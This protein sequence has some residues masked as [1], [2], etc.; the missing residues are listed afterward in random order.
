M[1][2]LPQ[3]FTLD[4]PYPSQT[5][6]SAAPRKLT[7]P[8]AAPPE[9]FT[10]DTPATSTA[11]A[12]APAAGARL[13]DL[14]K[15][16]AG[17][18]IGAVG[19][20]VR[21]FGEGSR[22]LAR[23]IVGGVNAFAG[24]EVLPEPVNPL[25]RPAAAIERAGRA[26][27]DS[28]SQAYRDQVQ[29]T[30]PTGELTRPST[31]GFEGDPTALGAAGLL[32]RSVGSVAP[33]L[34]SA[35]LTRGASLPAALGATTTTAAAQGGGFAAQSEEERILQMPE[36]M[37]AEVPAYRELLAGGAT[38]EAARSELAQRTGRAAFETTAPVSALS[39]LIIGGPITRPVQGA[40]ARAIGGG[41]VR[42]AAVEGGLEAVAEG[43]QEVA[44]QAA[45]IGG[46]NRATGES[47]DML[48]GS[49]ANFALGAATGGVIGAGTGALSRPAPGPLSRAAGTAEAVGLTRPTFPNAAP[50][51]M[52]DAAN[53]IPAGAPA[54]AAAADF[55]GDAQGNVQDARAPVDA[56]AAPSPMDA[57]TVPAEQ[58]ASPVSASGATQPAPAPPPSVP[59]FD[60]ATGEM[61]APTDAEVKDQFHTMFETASQGGSSRAST[62]ASRML[63]EEWGVPQARLKALRNE[64]V[65]ERKAGHK[66]GAPRP[67]QAE[68]A[69][70]TAATSTTEET[71]AAQP[72]ALE[73]TR[74]ASELRADR[75]SA[76]PVGEERPGS[77]RAGTA[78]TGSGEAAPAV[79]A[80]EEGAAAG[81][82]A[83]AVGDVDLSQRQ[84][85][86][87][88]GLPNGR[89]SDAGRARNSD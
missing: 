36:P 84:T 55:V 70:T 67:E 43:A 8:S 42:R 45:Q 49:L 53:A 25:T 11:A 54:A 61:R 22:T 17:S 5:G 16:I 65:A 75:G 12:P 33:V 63:A 47:R 27:Q 78:A 76:G 21:G 51:S 15:D 52:A 59:W 37:L 56:A 88:E 39:G 58:A 23:P 57:S 86:L 71:N 14:P 35:A 1:T 68:L 38:P 13:S 6:G 40:L 50:G 87:D 73:G 66:P 81:E 74:D 3:G 46:A 77:D 79:E 83:A 85:A 41:A 7:R 89:R 60:A 28:T 34:A 62:A 20:T 29:A 32:V 10:I 80:V 19:S 18:A 30:T 9:G 44:E 4:R 31:W 48:E 2:T 82:G 72:E 69:P 26:V 24:R 64:A